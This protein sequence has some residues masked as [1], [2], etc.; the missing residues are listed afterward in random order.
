MP[1]ATDARVVHEAAVVV[2]DALRRDDADVSGAVE[3]RADLAELGGHVLVVVDEL[4]RR[5]NG[6]PVGRP[7]MK[8]LQLRVPNAGASDA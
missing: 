1:V 6:P 5:P 3:L 2:V 4:L 8:S 7:G